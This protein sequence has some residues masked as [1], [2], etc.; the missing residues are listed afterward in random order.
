MQ[1]VNLYNGALLPKPEALP[2]ATLWMAVA[3]AIV[4]TM[5]MWFMQWSDVNEVQQRL[6]KLT[7]QK[8][9]MQQQLTDLQAI[10]LSA[11]EKVIAER[12]IKKL[13]QQ[14]Q[15]Q[16]QTS[17]LIAELNKKQ[18][19]GYSGVMEDLA[20]VNKKHLWLTRIRL[21]ADQ[22]SLEGK[23]FESATVA[24]M[25]NQLQELP[26][27]N[28]INFRKV[29]IERKSAKDRTASFYLYADSEGASHDNQ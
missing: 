15:Q 28:K 5:I 10:V 6:E 25:V 22:L 4:L 17:E 18:S 23:T 2:L 29:V 24:N 12:K 14:L 1:K 9:Q 20:N 26:N 13:Q 11:E 16:Q 27:T 19:N 7:Q 21:D 3:A 8:N